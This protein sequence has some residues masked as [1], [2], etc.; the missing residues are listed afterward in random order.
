[1]FFS[2]YVLTKNGPLA[3]IWLAAHWERRLTRDE[4][5]VVDLRKS[6]LD[7]VQ[8]VVPIALRTS[9]ELL[10]GVVRIY[11]LK[12]DH[13]L[14][15]ALGATLVLHVT[16]LPIAP[17]K[18][19][20]GVASGDIVTTKAGSGANAAGRVLLEGALLTRN[21]NVGAV[22]FNWG[23]GATDRA[24]GVL[25][26]ADGLGLAKSH[27][28][29]LDARFD[30]VADLL[31]GPG[32]RRRRSSG[33]VSPLL[34]PVWYT[35]EPS[36]QIAEE[37]RNT[38][39][40]YDEIAKLR[41]D[42]MAFGDDAS[43]SG[44][45]KSSLPSI[46]KGRSSAVDPVD[47]AMGNFMPFPLTGYDLDIGAPLPD[48]DQAVLL[49]DFMLPTTV[50]EEPEAQDAAPV[51]PSAPA[52]RKLPGAT[53]S[54][55]LDTASTTISSDVVQ[56]WMENRSDITEAVP[57]RGP[58]DPQEA[59]DRTEL[60][61]DGSKGDVWAVVDAAPL[62]LVPNMALAALF[63]DALRPC[64]D[65]RVK[66]E[67]AARAVLRKPQQE[68]AGD[69]DPF[70]AAEGD[71][72]S[73]EETPA[74]RKRTRE[75]MEAYNEDIINGSGANNGLSAVVLATLKR[76]REEVSKNSGPS[77]AAA[78]RNKCVLQE[79]CNGMRR[80]E[81]ARTF[82][83]VLALASKNLLWAKQVGSHVEVGLLEGAEEALL[84]A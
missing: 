48:D 38:Q 70:I 80:R 33:E 78:G 32:F 69:E 40:N 52:P 17:G 45:R 23:T 77:A 72:V 46:E 41:A 47:G 42:L 8:P 26:T 7:I 76:I 9:G 28:D 67:T 35:V 5:R 73:L 49:P 62:A 14:K 51:Q 44:S 61:R 22:T 1:M 50:N 20:K 19:K 21:G 37:L 2:T 60:A 64:I 39:E 54:N 11:A 57:R 29:V 75:E 16:T 6:V 71:L 79:M 74:S 12:V 65:E 10:V 34:G 59:R 83:S 68:V 3:K 15:D 43:G 58:L 63:A 53:V 24:S 55:L 25:I 27:E 56:R 66:A 84:V 13:L 82:V 81:A 4:V 36:S 18:G 30:D 31:Q